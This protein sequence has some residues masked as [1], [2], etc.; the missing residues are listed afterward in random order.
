MR[1]IAG[2][3]GFPPALRFEDIPAQAVLRAEG[4]DLAGRVEHLFETVKHP[5]TGEPYTDA[6]VARMSAS[7]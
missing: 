5:G 4:R 6:Q 2:A 1:A 3:M 7:P